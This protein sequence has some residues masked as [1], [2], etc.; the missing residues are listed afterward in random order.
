VV[1]SGQ[2]RYALEPAQSSPAVTTRDAIA[3]WVR[4][5]CQPVSPGSHPVAPVADELYTC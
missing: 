1:A 2:V 3:A 5:N 4:A